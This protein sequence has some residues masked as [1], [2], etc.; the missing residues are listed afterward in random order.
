LPCLRAHSKLENTEEHP[1]SLANQVPD[2]DGAWVRRVS[3][4]VG[5]RGGTPEGFPPSS[6]NGGGSFPGCREGG[7]PKSAQPAGTEP[8]NRSLVGPGEEEGASSEPPS[9]RPENPAAK[10]RTIVERACRR[11]QFVG[12][13]ANPSFEHH[14]TDYYDLRFGVNSL[15]H[16]AETPGL[17]VFCG[18]QGIR[19]RQESN[20]AVRFIHDR[21]RKE[22]QV[23]PRPGK[24]HNKVNVRFL[25]L[26]VGVPT[27]SPGASTL[28][29]H[30]AP[31]VIPRG[32]PLGKIP[33]SDRIRTLGVRPGNTTKGV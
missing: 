30:Q 23:L 16:T 1:T 9:R 22:G 17:V 19:H 2:R 32:L 13:I 27:S 6:W 20:A 8:H 10:S 26:A 7:R 24:S 29:G 28:S 4:Y 15:P 31:T 5:E 12:R 25:A 11:P 33:R 3:P 21:R 14:R 18:V